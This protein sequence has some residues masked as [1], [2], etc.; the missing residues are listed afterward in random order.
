M[1]YLSRF[2]HPNP[3]FSCQSRSSASSDRPNSSASS[4]SSSS[5]TAH[6]VVDSSPSSSSSSSSGSWRSIPSSLPSNREC[7]PIAR[8]KTILSASR[9]S[10]SRYYKALSGNIPAYRLHRL[11]HQTAADA[12]ADADDHC[13]TRLPS[14]SCYSVSNPSL[15]SCPHASSSSSSSPPVFAFGCSTRRRR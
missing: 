5:S 12:V 9:Y 10:V 13:D 11:S 7:I 15:S 2:L 8:S 4:S 6:R 14:L 3:S 1:N